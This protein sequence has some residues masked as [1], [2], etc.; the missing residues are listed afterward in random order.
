MSRDGENENTDVSAQ[1]RNGKTNKTEKNQKRSVGCSSDDVVV[2][3][4]KGCVKFEV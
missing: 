3:K 4:C 2:A 1:A